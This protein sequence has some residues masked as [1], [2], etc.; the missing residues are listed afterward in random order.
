MP[1]TKGEAAVVEFWGGPRDGEK[2]TLAEFLAQYPK[3]IASFPSAGPGLLH[4]Y[5]ADVEDGS[6]K[7][8]YV[9][10]LTLDQVTRLVEEEA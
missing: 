6:G 9:G 4:V 3:K 5:K 2:T 8:R 7:V 10:E 1:A